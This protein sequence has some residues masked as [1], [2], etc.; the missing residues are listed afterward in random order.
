MLQL[1]ESGE[2]CQREN[3]GFPFIHSLALLCI[4]IDADLAS[5]KKS[6]SFLTQAKTCKGHEGVIIRVI[7]LTL[8]PS[9]PS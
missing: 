8:Q 2:I 9:P 5:K 6:N 7:H 3:H 4:Q 1:K